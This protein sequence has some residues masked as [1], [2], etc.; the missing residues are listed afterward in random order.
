MTPVL[1]SIPLLTRL[2][3]L[4]TRVFARRQPLRECALT[5]ILRPISSPGARHTGLGAWVFLSFLTLNA[6]LFSDVL[7]AGKAFFEFDAVG[8]GYPLHYFAA[9][10]LKNGQFPLWSPYYAFGYPFF[11]ESQAGLLYPFHLVLYLA[12]MNQFFFWYH[13][14]LIL[15][16]A[17]AGWF[18]FLWVKDLTE[19]ES[20]GFFA[21]IT[22]MLGGYLMGHQIH[23]N[24][25][26]V[27]TWCPLIL[28]LMGRRMRGKWLWTALAIGVA[29]AFQSLAGHIPTLILFLPG[30]FA[31]GLWLFVKRRMARERWDSAAAPAALLAAGGA[32][33][34]I[35]AL[36]QILP[37]ALYISLSQRAGGGYLQ[38]GIPM[39]QFIHLFLPFPAGTR[40]FETGLFHG[41]LGWLLPL[42]ALFVASRE[43]R[44]EIAVLWC[45]VF[46]F[47]YL[48]LGAQSQ[49]FS[50]LHS[51]PPFSL[52][53]YPGRYSLDV[54]L[55]VSA[56]AGVAFAA[57]ARRWGGVLRSLPGL[58]VFVQGVT[59][60]VAHRAVAP[61]TDAR[62]LL[63]PPPYFAQIPRGRVPYRVFPTGL[64][65]YPWQGPEGMIAEGHGE[66]YPSELVSQSLALYHR[67]FYAPAQ[68]WLFVPAASVT[69]MSGLIRHPGPPLYSAFGV[70]YLIVPTKGERSKVARAQM[71]EWRL[72]RI[73]HT[74]V[75]DVYENPGARP[76]AFLATKFKVVPDPWSVWK[77][78]TDSRLI[79]T[80]IMPN[81]EAAIKDLINQMQNDPETVLLDREPPTL[82]NYQTE[83]TP[84]SVPNAPSPGEITDFLV[85]GRGFV[86]RGKAAQDALLVLLDQ[87]MPGWRAQVN[88]QPADL[89]RANYFFKAVVVPRGEFTA[90]FT[91]GLLPLGNCQWRGKP[92]ATTIGP[93]KQPLAS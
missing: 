78:F 65:Q 53:R 81:Y 73:V 46:F 80:V 18:M 8:A 41:Y 61:R 31:Y 51:I 52:M 77:R 49:L 30:A 67:V 2:F 7:F 88:H 11:L 25:V 33:G 10:S 60:V 6:L 85:T 38:P 86:I 87:C 37:Q 59:L 34:L 74:S 3:G 93:R 1:R 79:G 17:L 45:L 26:E 75:A 15:H 58:I 56:A 39:N 63:K 68:S 21:G 89:Y 83:A 55:F 76:M 14:L 22:F 19:S 24:I 28:Y 57:V 44:R 9:Q 50:L 35:L 5:P 32:I 20:A 40:W 82:R 12:P 84:G 92:T 90:V 64:D 43:I 13:A 27:V 36:P 4:R 70:R 71:H 16:Y 69:M 23:L 62:W 42:A 66:T 29:F 47:F 54:S 48:A 91:Y 72:A